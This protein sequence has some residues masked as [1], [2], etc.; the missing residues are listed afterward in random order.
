MDILER[1]SRDLSHIQLKWFFVHWGS[2]LKGFLTTLGNASPFEESQRDQLLCVGIYTELYIK[3]KPWKDKTKRWIARKEMSPCTDLLCVELI[4]SDLG[5]L[6]SVPDFIRM[7]YKWLSIKVTGTSPQES[8]NCNQD[9]YVKVQLYLN[10]EREKEREIRTFWKRRKLNMPLVMYT[11]I[12]EF[13]VPKHRVPWPTH[14]SLMNI[15][16]H[17][18]WPYP[19][20]VNKYLVKPCPCE[21]CHRKKIHGWANTIFGSFHHIQVLM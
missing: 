3:G 20:S 12:W 2:C 15:T 9:I 8:W 10:Q 4:S 6:C 5:V 19:G 18:L 1:C 13:C 16:E 17:M 11:I 21:T 14:W 7:L